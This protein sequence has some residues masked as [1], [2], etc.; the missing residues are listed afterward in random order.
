MNEDYGSFEEWFDSFVDHVI[1][2]GYDGPID[3]YTFESDY[4]DGKYPD[5]SAKE[6]V[7]EMKS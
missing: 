7:E 2:L 5:E 1:R 3:K 6:F 4:E